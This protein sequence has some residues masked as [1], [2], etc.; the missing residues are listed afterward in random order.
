MQLPM[1]NHVHN[2][3]LTSVIIICLLLFLAMRT[4]EHKGIDL[5]HK[6]RHDVRIIPHT[7]R[8]MFSSEKLPKLHQR[9]VC[10]RA[11]VRA[12][13]VR[14]CV[15]MCERVCMCVCTK[16]CIICTCVYVNYRYQFFLMGT[17]NSLQNR[18]NH[19]LQLGVLDIDLQLYMKN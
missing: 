3:Y 12:C 18:R 8:E 10:V 4:T 17:T 11:Y 15:R 9:S 5:K 2:Y 7:K 16:L 13:M 19:I 14:V 6:E 1:S